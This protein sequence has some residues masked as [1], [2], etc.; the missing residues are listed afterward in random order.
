MPDDNTQARTQTRSERLAAVGK[1]LTS[2]RFRDIAF[3]L[4]LIA[5]EALLA[6]RYGYDTYMLARQ[7]GA[8]IQIALTDAAMIDGVFVLLVTI[9]HFAGRGKKASKLRPLTLAGAAYM[10]FVVMLPIASTQ[11][12]VAR[13]ARIAGA[14]MLLFVGSDLLIDLWHAVEAWARKRKQTNRPPFRAR[15]RQANANIA[16]VFG[17][18]IWLLPSWVV[19]GFFTVA[20][21]YLSDLGLRVYADQQPP[22]QQAV[23]VL[24]SNGSKPAKLQALI[25]QNAQG[26]YEWTC[27]ACNQTSAQQ[28]RGKHD[29]DTERGAQRGF[30]GHAGAHSDELLPV[31]VEIVD[32]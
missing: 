20:R 9:A 5:I 13:A 32:D 19:L 27:P 30:A 18:W 23:R 7:E 11:G 14:M 15:L 31:E 17:V 16:Y 8:S 2:A 25:T 3:V 22:A 21:D 1:F 24:P 6:Y 29:Y 28:I 26:R 4:G 10:Y 12:Q